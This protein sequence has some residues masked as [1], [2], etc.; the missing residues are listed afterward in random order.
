[1]KSTHVVKVD[2]RRQWAELQA[3]PVRYLPIFEAFVT[4]GNDPAVALEGVHGLG[5]ADKTA[6]ERLKVFLDAVK[7]DSPKAVIALSE[8]SGNRPYQAVEPSRWFSD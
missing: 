6:I 4:Y 8:R 1:M 2:I 3:L 5:S 7:K